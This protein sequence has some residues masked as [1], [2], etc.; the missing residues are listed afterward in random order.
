MESFDL[1]YV[2]VNLYS[3]YGL[4]GTK[5]TGIN[6]L[7][8]GFFGRNEIRFSAA[9]EIYT[10]VA[11]YAPVTNDTG[12]GQEFLALY[13]NS[14]TEQHITV[15]INPITRTVEAKCG[16]TVLATA[17]APIIQNNVWRYIEVHAKLSDTVGIVQ[18]RVDEQLVIDF[19][20]DTKNGGSATT[21]DKI[22]LG[23]QQY[24][25][26]TMDDFYLLDTTGT[27]NNT[28][29]G[30]IDVVALRPNGNGSSS[31]LTG[32]DADQINNYQLVDD[33]S[34]PSM[35]DYVAGNTAGL[36]DLYALEDVPSNTVT[37][38]GV[39]VSYDAKKSAAGFAAAKP[40]LK[41]NGSTTSETM[42]PLSTSETQYTSAIYEA[43]PSGADWTISNMNSAEAGIETA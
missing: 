9:A 19:S 12:Y 41:A 38:R 4:S 37:V 20:G 40:V 30:D 24:Y 32:S 43:D 35:T 23:Y 15:R 39:R 34:T 27:K 36:L 3:T 17:V 16:A 7:S 28:W 22:G 13:G 21:F 29:L 6:G 25:G 14:G 42:Q 31:Q 33:P 10:G 11:L 8:V 1:G 5:R 26:G 2:P 18:V